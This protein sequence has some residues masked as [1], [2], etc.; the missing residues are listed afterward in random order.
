MAFKWIFPCCENHVHRLLSAKLPEHSGSTA[1]SPRHAA[2]NET[3]GEAQHHLSP[4]GKNHLEQAVGAG[5]CFRL[6]EGQ[7]G[8]CRGCDTAPQA[9]FHWTNLSLQGCACRHPKA[10][11]EP[12]ECP[13]PLRAPLEAA[14][15][16][17][18]SGIKPSPK[19]EAAMLPPVYRQ[20]TF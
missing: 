16:H 6:P 1:T 5:C 3:P 7:T 18:T 8:T 20:E 14:P 15:L 13:T 4:A 9:A 2:E 12:S 17:R 10:A 19:T 11:Q